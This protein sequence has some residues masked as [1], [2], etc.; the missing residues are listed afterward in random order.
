MKR[1]E[2]VYARAGLVVQTKAPQVLVALIVIAVL[3]PVVIASDA[4][5]GDNLNA[6][7]E[8]VILATILAAIVML[9]RGRF[10]FASIVPLATA[11][12]ALVGLSVLIKPES[13]HQL[14]TAVVYMVPAL[15]LSLAVGETEWHTVVVAGVGYATILG[16]GFLRIAPAVGGV[17]VLSEQLIIASVIFLLGSVFAFLVARTTRRALARVEIASK[18]A[19]DTLVQIGRV[20]DEARSSLDSSQSV[21][22]D[23][24]AVRES[25]AQIR[26]QV[27]VV[28]H[29]IASLRENVANALSFVR[30]TAD[31]VVG[32]HAQVD[33][34]N[35]VVQESTASVNEMSASLDSVAQITASKRQASEKLLEVV[36]DGLRAIEETNT[37]FQTAS[38]EMSSLLEINQIIADIASQTNLLSMNAAIEAAHAGD[39]GRGFAVVAE[40]IRKLASSTSE[41]SQIIADNLKR[42]MDSIEETSTHN[43]ATTSA[44]NRISGEV[45]EVAQAFEEITGS[46][47][48]L[49]SGGRE[50]MNAMQ[51]L[52]DSSVQVR[53]G[54]DEITRDQQRAREEMERVGK[55]VEAIESASEEVGR[56]IEAIGESM[57][58]LQKTIAG[59]SAQS[60]QVHASISSLVSG[61]ES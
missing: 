58:H 49:S 43:S 47:A 34:Q 2:Q 35:T 56:A 5:A 60:T 31:R 24:A 17:S 32:F 27:G 52:Q 36:A 40:E 4:L 59:S 25:V 20:S 28:E 48:E 51:V 13:N 41:N 16:V 15:L 1:L 3:L 57:G 37:S 54:S 53:D 7:I 9:Y 21:Q 22:T 46:T 42:L 18:R 33:E 29:S 10:R 8:T 12:I 61:L 19:T 30:A 14:Y 55:I 6:A 39:A 45:R 11:T 50:I 26:E 23:Y 38:R 44:M